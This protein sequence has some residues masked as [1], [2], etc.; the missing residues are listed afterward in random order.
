LP[1]VGSP[2]ADYSGQ[3]DGDAV[4]PDGIF[5][6]Q[7]SPILDVLEMENVGTFIGRLVYFTVIWY[8]LRSCG[9][10]Y[11]H[12][13]YFTVIWYILRSFRVYYC[14]LVNFLV[15][16][17]IFHGLVCLTKKNLATLTERFLGKNTHIEFVQWSSL[18][19]LAFKA[20]AARTTEAL[21]QKML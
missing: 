3:T 6:Y 13:V 7:K 15:V 8:I 11:G 18:I 19:G 1:K 9:I 12:L 14:H 10:F 21:H 5:S 2:N 17:Y 20:T 4:L 16:W